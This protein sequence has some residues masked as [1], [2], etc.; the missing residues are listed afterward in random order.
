MAG[1]RRG[2]SREG[3]SVH[4]RRHHQPTSVGLLLSSWCNAMQQGAVVSSVRVDRPSGVR[5]S[6]LTQTAPRWRCF[7]STEKRSCLLATLSSAKESNML[8]LAQILSKRI[9][10][11]VSFWFGSTN[12]RTSVSTQRALVNGPESQC[13]YEFQVCSSPCKMRLTSWFYDRTV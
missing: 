3:A 6:P 11:F 8:R 4:A 1:A 2:R 12:K 13:R 5:G 10:C 9:L 7:C